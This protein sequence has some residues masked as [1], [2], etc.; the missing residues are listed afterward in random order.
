[1]SV[2][3]LKP[4]L[5]TTLQDRGRHG[6]AAFGVGHAG[7]MDDV[8][9]RL[10]NALVGNPP[11]VPVLEITI[12]GPRL[13]FGRATTIALAG[14]EMSARTGASDFPMWQAIDVEAGTVLD[15]GNARR[16]ARAYLAIGH[17]IAEAVLGSASADVNARLGPALLREDDELRIGEI[18]SGAVALGGLEWMRKKPAV[19][20]VGPSI[21]A[22]SHSTHWSLDPRPWFDP[23][24]SH[25]IR[26]IEGAHF[27]ALDE[28]SR[29]AL[30][31]DEFRIAADSNRVG[32]RLEGPRLALAAPLE[33]VSEPVAFGTL[34]LPPGGQPVAL[35][36][37]HP[38]IGGYPRI[39]QI[40]AIDLPRLAQRRPGDAVRFAPIDLAD[41]QTRYLERERELECLIEAIGERRRR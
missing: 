1:M 38:T 26:L 6:H 17:L 37:E 30:F 41:A 11:N 34:Q 39:G 25:P 28:D 33:L 2:R 5:L 3:V 35:M 29:T 7:A 14:A 15:V 8:A 32:F 16:G 24:T 22:V 21:R 12:L 31:N 4:G 40:A 9:P 23:D 36:A 27:E 18:P 20:D 19:D 10:A 13:E